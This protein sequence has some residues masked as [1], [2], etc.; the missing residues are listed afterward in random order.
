MLICVL[1]KKMYYYPP[2]E[3]KIPLSAIAGA[4]LPSADDFETTLCNYLHVK[5]CVLGNS[6]R[7]LLYLLLASLK[8]KENGKRNE[9]LIPGY[10][11]YSVAASVA[12]AGLEI[13]IYDLN[14]ETLQPD[15]DSLKKAASEKTLAIISQHL[16]GIPTLMSELQTAAQSTGAYLIEDAAQ[17]LGGEI[18]GIPLGTIGDFGLY[19]FGRGKPLPLGCGGALIGKNAGSI[20]TLIAQPEKKGHISLIS[21]ALTRIIAN[22][23]LYRIPEKLPLG[24]GETVF[25]TDFDVAPMPCLIRKLAQKSMVALE[26][27]NTHRRRIAKIYEQAFNNKRIIPVPAETL[28]VYTRFPLMAGTSSIP[29][30]LKRLG[31]RQMYPQAILNVNSIKPHLTDQRN[32]A[33]G[34]AEIARNLITLPTHKGITQNRAKLIGHKLDTD[35]HRS[36]QI[37]KKA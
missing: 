25:S 35:L 17:A 31:A 21:T 26:D 24:L 37:K 29:G 22:P 18:K 27:L 1:F 7:A 16:F 10:T 3:T 6:G 11:C 28:P 19:S 34:A 13:K 14:P 9:V 36:T 4:F 8:K 15:Y 23:F 30:E 32:A 5:E 20:A 2:A 33:P 12:R